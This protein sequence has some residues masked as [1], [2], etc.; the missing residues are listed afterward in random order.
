M[1]MKLNKQL[2]YFSIDYPL[3]H[4]LSKHYVC[5][6][7]S[8]ECMGQGRDRGEGQGSKGRRGGGGGG[9][10]LYVLH[11]M[12][13]KSSTVLSKHWT[14]MPIDPVCSYTLSISIS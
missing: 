6:G 13:P 9:G 5:S 3:Q 8:K 7:R 2:C 11:T 14:D 12:P 4:Q 1:I 10:N